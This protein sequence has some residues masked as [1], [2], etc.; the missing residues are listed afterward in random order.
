MDGVGGGF[1]GAVHGGEGHGVAGGKQQIAGAVIKGRHVHHVVRSLHGG[2]HGAILDDLGDGVVLGGADQLGGDQLAVPVGV[3]VGLDDGAG[4]ALLHHLFRSLGQHMVHHTLCFVRGGDGDVTGLGILCHNGD[5]R[6]LAGG[7]HHDHLA[8]AHGDVGPAQQVIH[9][10]PPGGHQ[11]GGALSVGYLHLLALYQQ[12]LGV[13]AAVVGPN[14]QQTRGTVTV[15]P[16]VDDLH[17][18]LV[19]DHVYIAGVFDILLTEDHGGGQQSHQSNCQQQ[20]LQESGRCGSVR[21]WPGRRLHSDYCFFHKKPPN[22][23]LH[24]QG[25]GRWK[26]TSQCICNFCYFFEIWEEYIT[27]THFCQVFWIFHE[28]T[29]HFSRFCSGI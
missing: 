3:L 5:G 28:V 18:G 15:G 25:S 10:F 4:N 13:P 17:S 20:P 1:A 26:I 29:H 12:Q 2:D 22:S 8:V 21:C 16:A 19:Q 7:V 14:V 24:F 11:I 6:R 27:S 23:A 9:R